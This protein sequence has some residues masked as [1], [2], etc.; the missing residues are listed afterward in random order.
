MTVDLCSGIDEDEL[1]DYTM[2]HD[3]EEDLKCF[4]SKQLESKFSDWLEYM[5]DMN[6]HMSYEW[7]ETEVAA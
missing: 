3:P 4:S 5:H 6:E 2:P 1:E 7:Y